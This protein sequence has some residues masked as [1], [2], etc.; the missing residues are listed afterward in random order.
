MHIFYRGLLL[1]LFAHSFGYSQH[2]GQVSDAETGAIIADAKIYVP[3]LDVYTFTD[4]NGMFSI[5]TQGAKSIVVSILGYETQEVMLE[6][7]HILISLHPS[8]FEMEEVVVSTPFSN[9]R[10]QNTITV[11]TLNTESIQ[12]HGAA[13][14]ADALQRIPGVSTLSTGQ[15]IAKPVIRGLSGNRVVTYVNNLRYENYQFSND[16]GLDLG[17]SASAVEVIK[18]PFSLLYGADAIGGVIFVSPLTFTNKKQLTGAVQQRYFSQSL[19]NETNANFS[20]AMG[21]W[22]FATSG[23]FAHHADYKTT[24]EAF[25]PNSRFKSKG[26]GVN[27]RFTNGNY[28]ATFRFAYND[29]EAGIIE[30][31]AV[32][33]RYASIDVPYQ[34]TQLNQYSL[35]QKLNTTLGLWDLTTGLTINKRSE[36]E[37]HDEAFM[38]TAHEEDEAA[39]DMHNELISFDLR[40][41]LPSSGSW[42][43]IVGMQWNKQQ[44]TNYGEETIIPNATKKDLGLFWLHVIK[45]ENFNWQLGLRYDNR[46]LKTDSFIVHAHDYTLQNEEEVTSINRSF[47]RFNGSIGLTH[48]IF[49]QQAQLRLNLSTGFRAPN[50]AELTSHGVHHGTQRFEVGNAGL[51]AEHNLQFD[52]GLSM[53]SK[54]LNLGIDGFFNNIKNYIYLD[55]TDEQEANLQVFEYAQSDATLWGGELYVHYHPQGQFH[56]ESSLEYVRAKRQNGSSLPLIPPLAFHQEIHWA[57]QP[58]LATFISVDLVDKQDNI[59]AFETKSTGYGLLNIGGHFDIPI[60][61]G[62]SSLQLQL[63]VRNLTNTTYIPHLSR[64]KTIGVSQPGR[65]IVLSGSWRF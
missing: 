10:N 23:A 54:Y 31:A 53:K 63:L 40:N 1:T 62:G 43:Q 18:G 6:T 24:E 28:Q 51:H 61:H 46:W 44:N 36:F 7:K 4:D 48:A 37:H 29:K 20:V 49:S 25:V 45:N 21:K 50:L 8:I 14:L 35:R 15:G 19:G 26:T 39:L 30:D 58:E 9:L 60:H 5:E 55:P 22:Q 16:H 64:L 52:F 38:D 17:A 2:T 59:G 41:T 27:T 34:A 33:R 32:S 56:F 13:V 57:I 42:Q 47:D 12:E 11:S 3:L 65:N